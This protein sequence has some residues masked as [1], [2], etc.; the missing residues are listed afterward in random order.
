[1]RI[2]A[3]V[4]MEA[5]IVRKYVRVGFS[6]LAIALLA[7]RFAPRPTSPSRRPIVSPRRSGSFQ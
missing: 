7:C 2:V 4:T 5:S 3:M 1:M 6:P